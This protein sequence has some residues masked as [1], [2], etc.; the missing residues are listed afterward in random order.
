MWSRGAAMPDFSER[1][2]EQHKDW[3]C[4]PLSLD[5][6]LDSKIITQSLNDNVGDTL[7]SDIYYRVTIEGIGYPAITGDGGFAVFPNGGNIDLS[8]GESF[9]AQNCKVFM[10]H[11]LAIHT[12]LGWNQDLQFR[13]SNLLWPRRLAFAG[14]AASGQT[15]GKLSQSISFTNSSAAILP[16]GPQTLSSSISVML[17][18]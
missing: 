15:V 14:P 2:L 16:S 7:I 10:S 3:I 18:I 9:Y 8:P 13:L 1:N 17:E 6:A 5:Y 4:W 12:R 11:A